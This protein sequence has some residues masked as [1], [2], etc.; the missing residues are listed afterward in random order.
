MGIIQFQKS[1]NH[2]PDMYLELGLALYLKSHWYSGKMTSVRQII[3]DF[4]EWTTPEIP[5]YDLLDFYW[6]HATCSLASL[7][8][9]GASLS[10]LEGVHSNK[11]THNSLL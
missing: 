11:I 2:V 4:Q 5:W 7:S 1:F 3:Q 10:G 8:E 6:E 9:E